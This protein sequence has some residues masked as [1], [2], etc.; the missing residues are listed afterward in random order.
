MKKNIFSAFLKAKQTKYGSFA[1]ALTIVFIAVIL[2]VN[3][4]ASAFRDEYGLV[5]DVTADQ[6]Y[7]VSEESV[8]LIEQQLNDPRFEKTPPHIIITFF[9]PK[10]N[11]ESGEDYRMVLRSAQQY[12]DL[13]PDLIDIVFIDSIAEP[14]KL[15]QHQKT[16]EDLG[17]SLYS[18][19]VLIECDLDGDQKSDRFSTFYISS[20]FRINEETQQAYAYQGETKFT[21]A[22]LTLTSEDRPVVTFTQGHGEPTKEKQALLEEMFTNAGFVAK[23][24]NTRMEEID[25]NTRIL[26][27]YAP[28]SD[29]AGIMDG[30]DA[31]G[32]TEI[33]RIS[34]F[35]SRNFA[36]NKKNSA[37]M[38]FMDASTPTLPELDALIEKWGLSVNRTTVYDHDKS[39]PY[40]PNYV[41][42]DYIDA[43]YNSDSDKEEGKPAQNQ[44][45][46]SLVDSLSTSESS[47]PVVF[48]NGAPIIVTDR[49]VAHENSEWH[50]EPVLTTFPSAQI[51]KVENGETITVKGTYNLAALSSKTEIV[52]NEY[53]DYHL[54]VFGTT[55]YAETK[56]IVD[57]AFAN[58]P[59]L[60]KSMKI[61]GDLKLVAVDIE[62]KQFDDTAFEN[63][64]DMTNENWKSWLIRLTC[65]MPGAVCLLGLAV[66]VRR[67]YL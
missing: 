57:N 23:Y 63:A 12:A 8:A 11:L 41:V 1:L 58:A 24:T 52:N 46:H 21:S 28:K 32:D 38:V 60:Y 62:I 40:G 55:N 26:V 19:S 9:M 2:A 47:T 43:Y 64:E 56:L 4:V 31:A 66:W 49:S 53:Y 6:L 15:I 36:N 39:L 48:I 17:Y 29:F 14:D 67:R 61:L 13:F 44:I 10:I 50:I 37:V 18:T 54:M 25:P 5:I 27:I 59:F 35:L 33:N 20:C 45:A 34:N 65:A 16:F 22:I 30:E 7:T 3:L 51:N 42:A